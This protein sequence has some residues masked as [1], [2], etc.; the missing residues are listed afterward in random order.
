MNLDLA[1]REKKIE[2]LIIN[3][4]IFFLYNLIF[5]KL[6]FDLVSIQGFFERE[7]LSVAE[8]PKMGVSV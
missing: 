1:H 5:E 2:F 6:S 3:Y 7:N 8:T 4:N